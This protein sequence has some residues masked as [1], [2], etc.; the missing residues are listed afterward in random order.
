MNSQQQALMD[1]PDA[2][3]LEDFIWAP[4]QKGLTAFSRADLRSRQFVDSQCL[5]FLPLPT[6]MKCANHPSNRI[7]E[8]LFSGFSQ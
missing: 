8:N 5:Q 2:E 6:G 4:E 3:S 7:I 1:I